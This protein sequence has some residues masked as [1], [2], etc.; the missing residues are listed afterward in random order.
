MSSELTEEQ[1]KNILQGI[2]IPPQ[3]QILVDLQM[4][5]AMPDPDIRQIAR[6]VSQDVGLSGTMLKFVNSP[7]FGLSNK[8]TSIEQAVSL[9]GLNS[10]INILNGLSIKG[11][12]T[13]EKIASLTRFWD[14]ANDIAMVSATIAKQIGYHS[15]DAAYSLGLFH[16]A[17]IPLMYSRFDNYDDIMQEAYSGVDIRIIDT[18][19][20]LLN[21]N[22]AVIG[23][24]TAKSWNLPRLICEV[25]AEHHSAQTIFEK[26]DGQ[27]QD[28][29]TLLAILKIAEHICGN[30]RVLGNQNIDYEWQA[31]GDDILEYVGLTSIDIGDMKD[32]FQ[33]MGVSVFTD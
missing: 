10:V 6:L 30:Y 4:E 3:P 24:Y 28:K 1:I 12:M 25:I 13:D 32:N 9:L 20:R 16:N 7:F 14:T 17:G 15:P 2:K 29:K 23:Y 31:S 27:N 19:N 5:Q 33:D 21:T 26:K 8:I 22:H 18:E 11:E